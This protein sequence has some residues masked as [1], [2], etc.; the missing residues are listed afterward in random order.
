M[1]VSAPIREEYRRWRVASIVRR[2]G[3]DPAR[4]LE[5]GITP[6][7][8]WSIAKPKQHDEILSVMGGKAGSTHAC[9]LYPWPKGFPV[10]RLLRAAREAGLEYATQTP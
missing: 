8:Y 3:V 7:G 9:Y 6:W 2:G 4:V 5:W 1:T 10:R